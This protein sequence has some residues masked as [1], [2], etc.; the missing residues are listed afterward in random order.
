MQGL[1]AIHHR[2][3]EEPLVEEG[4]GDPGAMDGAL[5]VANSAQTQGE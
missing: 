2:K 5:V 1:W 4:G 3:E